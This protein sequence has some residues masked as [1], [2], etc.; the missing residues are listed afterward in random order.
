MKYV[1]IERV[2]ET[3]NTICISTLNMAIA[4]TKQMTVKEIALVS[5]KWNLHSSQNSVVIF[6]RELC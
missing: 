4:L 3:R 2:S 1:S 5:D 6:L